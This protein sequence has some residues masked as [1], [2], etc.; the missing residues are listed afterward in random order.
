MGLIDGSKIANDIKK[1]LS[2]EISLLK[3]THN[4]I[5]GLATILI[6]DDPGS[7][8][9]VRLKQKA[10]QE[11]GIYSEKIVFP[12]NVTEEK[13]FSSIKK[14][15]ENDKI[16]GILVQLPLPNHL[17]QL[18]IMEKIKP[19]KDVDG[20]NPVNA[21]KLANRDESGFIP[22]TPKGIL[23]L[24]E[25][26]LPSLEGKNITI[27]NH[28]TVI[29]RPLAMLLLNRNATVTICHIKTDNLKKYTQNADIIITAAGVPNLI[30]IDM[31][32]DGV[33]IIDAGF[34][35]VEGKIVGDADFEN[36]KEKSSHITPPTGGVGPMTI[37]MLLENTVL[38][39]KK[40][41]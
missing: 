10:C 8:V 25:Q 38:A 37:A 23:Y 35:R 4:I 30:K 18:R 29:G 11:I 22:C 41:F 21:G 19:E 16:H 28:S 6:G 32:K 17:D 36:L 24:L 39:A 14:L 40:N 33:I 26:I 5:P 7:K 34:S 9:Y 3:K 31:V 12:N 27:I 20:F 13:I 15:N 1:E 2:N